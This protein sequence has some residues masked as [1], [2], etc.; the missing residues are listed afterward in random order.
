[1][2]GN[3]E[4]IS[5]LDSLFSHRRALM[6]A[7]VLET[8]LFLVL[9]ENVETSHSVLQTGIMWLGVNDIWRLKCFCFLFFLG[10]VMCGM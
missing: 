2:R 1:M 10:L 6:P 8:F 9:I 3:H 7:S 4:P 5:K